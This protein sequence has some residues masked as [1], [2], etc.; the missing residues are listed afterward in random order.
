MGLRQM[1]Q[2]LGIAPA[3]LT[4]LEKGRRTPSE[5]LLRRIAEVYKLEVAVLRAGWQKPDQAVAEAATRDATA[6]AKVP[7]FLRSTQGLT[8]EQWDTLIAQ[9]RK[10]TGRRGGKR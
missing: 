10:M 1:A 6:A 5:A 3:H 8:P 7:E 9:A 4:D 2:V